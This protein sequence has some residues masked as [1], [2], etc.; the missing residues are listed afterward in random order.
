MCTSEVNKFIIQLKCLQF[1]YE[2]FSQLGLNNIIH[3]AHYV[4]SLAISREVL[5]LLISVSS[6]RPAAAYADQGHV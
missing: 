1:S 4:C 2:E 3:N 6:K 5:A